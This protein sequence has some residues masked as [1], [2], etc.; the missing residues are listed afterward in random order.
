M[1][2]VAPSP[3][4][5][6][7]LPLDA[8]EQLVVFAS[9]RLALGPACASLVLVGASLVLVGAPRLGRRVPRFESAHPSFWVGK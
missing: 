6:E 3:S 5:V 4:S 9:S 7:Y 2:T 1:L 8:A